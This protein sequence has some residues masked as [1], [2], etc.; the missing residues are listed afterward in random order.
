[1]QCPRCQ[2]WNRPAAKFCDECGTPFRDLVGTAHSLSYG[3]LQRALTEALDQQTAANEILRVIS[4]APT[5]LQPVLDAIA[6]NA[7]RVCGAY[8]AT[9]L[10]RERDFTRRVA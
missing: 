8:D 2:R 6:A 5:N 7:A 10:L 9:V 3:D 1:M 4:N